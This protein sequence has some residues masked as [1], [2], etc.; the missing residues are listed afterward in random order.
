[1]KRTAAALLI[2]LSAGVSAPALAADAATVLAG[3]SQQGGLLP[4]HVD[5][6]GGR[7]LLSLPR[8]DR[9]GLLGRYLYVPSLKTGLGSAPVGLDRALNGGSRLIA[10]RRLGKKVVVEVENPRFRATNAPGPEQAAAR[11]SFAYSTLWTGDVAAETADGR[12]LV[13]ISSFLTRDAMGI[14]QALKGAGEKGFALSNDLTVA[15]P[16]AVKVFPENI[17]LEARQ[18]FV[19]SEPGAEVNN[20]S[21]APGNLTFVV[22][23]S[24]VKLPDA[25]Y[26]PLRFDPRTGSFGSQVL[27]YAAPLGSPIVY[28]LANRFRLEKVDP[29]APRS[30]VKKPIT[31]YIDRSAPE[32]IR[33]ALYEG[34]SWWRQAFEDAGFIDAFRVEI[35]PDGIDPL[36]VRY[37]VVNWVNRATRGW[38]YG[39]VIEDPRTGEIIKGQVLLGSLRVRQDMLIFEGLVGADKVGRGGPNDPVQ[40]SLARL[41]QLAAHEVGHA[42]GFAHN[43]A[44]ST[45]GRFSVMDYPAPRVSLVGGA[46]DL[47]DAYGAG[48]GRWDQFVVDW[49]YGSDSEAEARDKASAAVAEGLRFVGDNEARPLGSA[50]PWGGLWDDAADPAGELERMLEV[51]RAAVNRFGLGALAGGEPVANLR[52]KF[53]PI[54]LLHRY[55]VEAASKLV[56]G[57]TFTYAVRGDGTETAAPVEEGLQ[58]RALE[59]LLATLSPEALQVPAHLLPHL[60]SGWSGTPDRQFDIEIFRT[61][62]GPVFDP[63][64]ASDAAAMVTLNSLLAPDRLN[65]LAE[66]NRVSESQLGATETIDRLIATVFSRPAADSSLAAVQRRIATTTAFALA[67]VQRDPALSPTLS[68]ALDERLRRLSADLAR[69]PGNEAERDWSRGL[70][71]LLTD[72]EALDKVLGEPRRLPQVPPGMPI[73]SAADEYL[74]G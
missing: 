23:H 25:G 43:F 70:A 69:R 11:E 60:S 27:D 54:W 42:L 28:D 58:R 13:D 56:G 3:T 59:G 51:R 12:V 34:T 20:I 68:L 32:P 38:S 37:N 31:F 62:G 66:Q 35:L 71:R 15:D 33:T 55:Q 48:L 57:V 65:R 1:M 73:G 10:F 29:A 44:G 24:L 2:F 18:T 46:P 22:R 63:L 52:R 47:S 53:V 17:E 45:Q 9:E 72:G 36:D 49:L 19:S 8:P 74:G 30:R 5:Q 14:A 7:I 26:Q 21:P 4:V 64:A 16:H 6:K 50:Q 40:A 41:R 61:A 39:Q 67:R